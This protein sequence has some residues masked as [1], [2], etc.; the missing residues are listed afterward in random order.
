MKQDQFWLTIISHKRP[1]NV[2]LMQQF[3]PLA[4]WYVRDED[5]AFMYRLS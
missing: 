4:T 3:A 2:N 5:E 1:A